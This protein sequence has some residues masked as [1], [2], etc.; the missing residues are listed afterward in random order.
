MLVVIECKDYKKPVGI[1]K[2]EAFAQKLNDVG[3]NLGVMI[4]TSG[5]D[6]GAKVIATQNR[7]ML[8]T[9]REAQGQDWNNLL[10]NKAWFSFIEPKE[11]EIHQIYAKL[12]GVPK[13]ILF[14]SYPNLFNHD[15]TLI[16]T[17]KGFVAQIY[18]SLSTD[19]QMPL[20]GPFEVS[21]VSTDLF[22]KDPN[23]VLYNIEELYMKLFLRATKRVLNLQLEQGQVLE[24][25][26]S[27]KTIY[28]KM[29]SKSFN[30]KE[31]IQ[32]NNGIEY[33]VEEYQRTLQ[34]SKTMRLIKS[35]PDHPYIR[36]TLTQGD[37]K[38]T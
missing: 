24:D 32:N 31:A 22:L 23:N 18:E 9:Y 14:M 29:R 30:W 15:G 6:E 38:E 2:L 20:V 11:I 19:D 36:I 13:P 8:R 16:G 35:N 33:T 21:V 5:F 4:S 7:I 25:A 1:E 27:S 28:K 12:Q 34:E 37:D 17:L 26:Q 10:G 3:A